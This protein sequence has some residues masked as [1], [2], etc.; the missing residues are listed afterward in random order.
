MWQVIYRLYLQDEMEFYGRNFYEG[1]I[2]RDK[3]H[4][5]IDFKQKVHEGVRPMG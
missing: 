3:F 2:F 4:E 1:S 5:G